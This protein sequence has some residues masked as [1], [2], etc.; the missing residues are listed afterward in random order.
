MKRRSREEWEHLIA[1]Q[2]STG[3][4]VK[5]FCQEYSINE[6]YFSCVKSKLKKEVPHKSGFQSLGA[7]VP[8]QTITLR[9]GDIV[10]DLPPTIDPAWLGTL[11]KKLAA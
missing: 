2:Q 7:F 10:I 4:S 5:Q 3:Q 8:L 9:H 6:H 1:Q 11:A